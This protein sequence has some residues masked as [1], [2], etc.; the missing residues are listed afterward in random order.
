MEIRNIDVERQ[1]LLSGV[2]VSKRNKKLLD[3]IEE[4]FFKKGYEYALVHFNIA[5]KELKIDK[6]LEKKILD[7]YM[8]FLKT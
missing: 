6:G 4:H 7:G 5:V 1:E 2:S 3:T 8:D